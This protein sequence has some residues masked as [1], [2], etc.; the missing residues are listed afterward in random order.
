[1][2]GLGYEPV[3]VKGVVVRSA[4]AAAVNIRLR[5]AVKLS[6]PFNNAEPNVMR[7]STSPAR[8][9]GAKFDG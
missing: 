5:V 3:L 8:T 9:Q 4:S 6:D 2:P 1:M 7:E